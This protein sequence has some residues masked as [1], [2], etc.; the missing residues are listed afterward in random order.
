MY[1]SRINGPCVQPHEVMLERLLAAIGETSFAAQL[2]QSALSQPQV[3]GRWH[4]YQTFDYFRTDVCEA[5]DDSQRAECGVPRRRPHP[6][7]PIADP[8]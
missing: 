3:S 6:R 4:A 8:P 1:D 5:I 7:A 2:A